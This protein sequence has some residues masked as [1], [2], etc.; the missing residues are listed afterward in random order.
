VIEILVS[1]A[2][3]VSVPPAFAGSHGAVLDF[4]GIVRGIENDRVIDGIEYEA[5]V[6]MAEQQMKLVAEAAA[7][8]HV[9]GQVILHH[10]IGFVAT[11][12]ASLFLRVSARHRE[13]AYK[14]SKQIVER[15]KTV[16]PI[17]KHPIFSTAQIA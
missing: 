12:E 5:F 6:S 4:Y 1:T 14:A 11:G 16:V 15:L 7:T 17:W 8:D 10:R 9:L 2:P 13:A 3:L